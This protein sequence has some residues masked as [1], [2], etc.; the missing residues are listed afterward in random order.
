MKL[1]SYCMLIF[2]KLNIMYIPSALYFCVLHGRVLCTDLSVQFVIFTTFSY[3][4]WIRIK[5]L[6]EE[7]CN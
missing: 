5:M 3:I 2:I 6:D 1:C 4:K 7:I